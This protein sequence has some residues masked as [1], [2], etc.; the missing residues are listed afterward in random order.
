MRP[1]E[2]LWLVVIVACAALASARKGCIHDKVAPRDVPRGEQTY[3]PLQSGR[4]SG[5]Q[6]DQYQPIRITFNYDCDVC[7]DN[8]GQSKAQ[9]DYVKQN[10]ERSKKWLQST[11]KVKRVVGNLK[12]SQTKMYNDVVTVPEKYRTTGVPDTDLLIFV[13]SSENDPNGCSEG[14]LAYA[15]HTEQDTTLDRPTFGIIDMCI[16][17][18]LPDV[19]FDGKKKTLYHKEE[20]FH[21]TLH[22]ITH[23]LGHSGALYHWFRDENGQPRNRRCTQ[24]EVEAADLRIDGYPFYCLKVND[25]PM[26][27][28]VVG[29]WDDGTD[30][31]DGSRYMSNTLVSAAAPSTLEKVQNRHTYLKTPKLL[32]VARKH[33]GCSTWS[34]V[35]LEDD[36]GSGSALSHWDKRMLM[37][38]FMGASPSH[39]VNSKSAFTLAL[40]EDSGWYKADYTKADPLAWGYLH[41]C[42]LFSECGMDAG[43]SI[44]PGSICTP[45]SGGPLECTHDRSG[46]AKC[47][48]S[49]QMDGCNYVNPLAQEGF[50][51]SNW[52]QDAPSFL[53][54]RAGSMPSDTSKC[55]SSDLMKGP[56]AAATDKVGCY[57]ARCTKDTTWRLEIKDPSGAWQVCE[58]NK[59]LKVLGYAGA[60][61]C[62]PEW[63]TWCAVDTGM[64]ATA[65]PSPA[66][67]PAPPPLPPP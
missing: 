7:V 45:D 21:T 9:Q 61:N 44:S 10:M 30:K 37:N 58:P 66:P 63:D 6:D 13:R 49:D 47:G 46:F 19:T 12:T 4:R 1:K 33:F 22:E 24:A 8:N 26:N 41:G 38:E 17:E 23:I 20:D 2:L 32:E 60:I 56:N 5:T 27:A 59:K 57:D 64:K 67:P 39:F 65:T 62:P 34:G 43:K 42:K 16:T 53:S 11:L 40:L 52:K 28:T 31:W 14:T 15:L 18:N 55:F 25:V 35:A 36:G 54:T 29:K 50:L 48:T 51:C 3:G